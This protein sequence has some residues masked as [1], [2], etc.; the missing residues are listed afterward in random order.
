ML[1]AD[2]NEDNQGSINDLFNNDY[3]YAQL[4][5]SM[6]NMQHKQYFPGLTS[7]SCMESPHPLALGFALL[8]SSSVQ[9]D[10]PDVERLTQTQR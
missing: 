10:E 2:M 1:A 9:S 6:G 4:S 3:L 8:V 7:W 5:E